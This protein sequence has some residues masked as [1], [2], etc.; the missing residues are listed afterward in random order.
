MDV[1]R[2]G[3]YL[4]ELFIYSYIVYVWYLFC[5][6]FPEFLPVYRLGKRMII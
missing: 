2:K 5:V 3:S 6:S 1:L 4:F